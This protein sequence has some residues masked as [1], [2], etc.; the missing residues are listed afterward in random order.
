MFACINCDV[1]EWIFITMNEK[2]V[3]S[4]EVIGELVANG[5]RKKKCLLVRVKSNGCVSI[6]H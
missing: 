1:R 6:G 5:L 2:V 4:C 3:T